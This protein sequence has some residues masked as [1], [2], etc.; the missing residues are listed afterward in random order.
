MNVDSFFETLTSGKLAKNLFLRFL[1]TGG[2]STLL[3]F[4]FLV[5]FIEVLHMPKVFAS[6]LSYALSACCNYFLN[7]YFTFTS[8]RHHGSAA[9]RFA[10]GVIF[11]LGI[12]A[13]SFWLLLELAPHYVLAQAGATVFTLFV[14]FT[15]QRLWVFD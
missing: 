1:L 12:S 7:Y 5:S 13:T 14:N 6:G 11:G 9:P 8:T 10:L 15:V 2:A 4:A 3:Q